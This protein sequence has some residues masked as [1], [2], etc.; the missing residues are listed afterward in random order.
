[1]KS[2]EVYD[3]YFVSVTELHSDTISTIST[4]LYTLYWKQAHSSIQAGAV[5]LLWD[6]SLNRVV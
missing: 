1:M 4:M 2:T 3:Q 6:I 5:R